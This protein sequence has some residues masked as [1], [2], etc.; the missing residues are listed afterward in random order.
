[1]SHADDV[2]KFAEWR[3]YH[4]HTVYESFTFITF[5][6]C[7]GCLLLFYNSFVVFVQSVL[8][9]RFPPILLLCQCTQ[10]P[11]K[12]KLLGKP[13]NCYVMLDN[14]ESCRYIVLLGYRYIRVYKS[15]VPVCTWKQNYYN[16]IRIIKFDLDP[17]WIIKL[18]LDPQ[19]ITGIK[20]DPDPQW[21]IN[22][23]PVPA[24]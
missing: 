8:L 22:F 24:I 3:R 14:L 23:D 21:I 9:Y 5:N 13:S 16:R 6:T 11:Q 4:S 2:N 18:D 1:M 20:L 17:Q 12:C 7:I 10:W 15:T 19:W